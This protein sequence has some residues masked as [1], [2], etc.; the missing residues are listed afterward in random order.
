MHQS[1]RALQATIVM[2]EAL[3]ERLLT[4]INHAAR[5]RKV[6]SPSSARVVFLAVL[7]VAACISLFVFSSKTLIKDSAEILVLETAH[8]S[9]ILSKTNF[10]RVAG[11]NSRELAETAK[12]IGLTGAPLAILGLSVGTTDV[13]QDQQGRKILRTC[14]QDSRNHSFCIDCYQAPSG[15]LSF[16]GAELNPKMRGRAQFEHI[17]NHNVIVLSK[18][19]VDYIYAS[20]LSKERLLALIFANT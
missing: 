13:L 15:L 20:T 10:H 12:S 5:K 14:F 16:K 17:G 3:E 1:I 19:G 8:G 4:A 9:K 11:V 18:N 7:A 2:P 6:G